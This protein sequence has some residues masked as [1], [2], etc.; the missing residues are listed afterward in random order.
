[1]LLRYHYI[2]LLIYYFMDIK[3]KVIKIGDSKGVILPA[4]LLENEDINV[5]DMIRITFKKA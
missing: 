3:L 2:L 1:M 4:K 5:N